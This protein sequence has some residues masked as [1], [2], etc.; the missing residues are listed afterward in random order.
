MDMEHRTRSVRYRV[1]PPS[2]IL[3]EYLCRS[4][5][6]CTFANYC[7]VQWLIQQIQ[8]CSSTSNLV[9]RQKMPKKEFYMDGHRV[10][11]DA[12]LKSRGEIHTTCGLPYMSSV[13]H[14]KRN[15]V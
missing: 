11:M 8:T 2:S 15:G 6:W 5:D 4:S 7:R 10:E 9:L 13:S 3:F 1:W 12:K 14:V